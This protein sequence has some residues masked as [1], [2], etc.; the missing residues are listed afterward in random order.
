MAASGVVA[1]IRLDRTQQRI[2]TPGDQILWDCCASIKTNKAEDA[3]VKP[4][5]LHSFSEGR[6]GSRKLRVVAV[7]NHGT[8]GGFQ[9]AVS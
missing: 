9:C 5:P 6:I 7:R 8:G 2:A 4:L 1:E 3:E